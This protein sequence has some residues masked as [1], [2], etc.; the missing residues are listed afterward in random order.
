MSMYGCGVSKRRREG[1]VVWKPQGVGYGAPGGLVELGEQPEGCPLACGDPEC[2]E[3]PEALFVG[4]R[5]LAYH[6]SECEL[7]DP[8]YSG[9]DEARGFPLIGPF[10]RVKRE[11][12]DCWITV[13]SFGFWA[14]LDARACDHEA[15]GEDGL[16][17]GAHLFVPG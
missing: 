10:R 17:H 3:W 9:Y 7:E 1:E 4:G 14:E 8:D 6:L 16:G 15:P 2:Q 13:D 12:C 5:E 11:C